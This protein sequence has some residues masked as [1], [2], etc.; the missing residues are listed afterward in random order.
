EQLNAVLLDRRWNIVFESDGRERKRIDLAARWTNVHVHV[1]HLVNRP[2]SIA[3]PKTRP[4]FDS[5]SYQLPFTVIHRNETWIVKHLRIFVASD[6]QVNVRDHADTKPFVERIKT[7]IR[8]R[9]D[10][11]L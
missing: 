6:V 9:A 10:N 3:G 8:L 2:D 1:I 5:H 7:P 4:T 11:F